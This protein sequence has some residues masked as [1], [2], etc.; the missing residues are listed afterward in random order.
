LLLLLHCFVFPRKRKHRKDFT[1][2]ASFWETTEKLFGCSLESEDFPQ[3]MQNCGKV[4]V[5]GGII[6]CFAMCTCIV[7]ANNAKITFC[8]A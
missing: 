6:I 5:V 3:T 4:V 7:Y 8:Q 1:K 2:L